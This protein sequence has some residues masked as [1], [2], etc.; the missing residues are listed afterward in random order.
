MALPPLEPWR[1]GFDGQ[2]LHR[3]L[4]IRAD[5]IGE[6]YV[7]FLV[8]PPAGSVERTVSTLAITT[9]VD[10]AVVMATGTTVDHRRESMNGTAEINLTYAREP[11]EEAVVRATVQH[12]GPALA[13]VEVR[14]TDAAGA[15]IA[16]GRGTYSIRRGAE[17]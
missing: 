8:A 12:R 11:G 7:Q 9:A 6:G 5:E 4:G 3:L 15:A 1:R 2:P 13:V 14:V 10:L 17:R 16:F